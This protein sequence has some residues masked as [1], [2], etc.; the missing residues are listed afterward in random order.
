LA[1]IVVNPFGGR[2]REKEEIEHHKMQ[3]RVG[4]THSQILHK[5]DE[6]PVTEGTSPTLSA[7][8][9]HGREIKKVENLAVRKDYVNG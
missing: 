4:K 2:P 8:F 9:A 3:E 5:E 6:E 1:V 7:P